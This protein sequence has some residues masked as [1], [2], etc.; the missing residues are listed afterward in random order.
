[1]FFVN[2]DG[3]GFDMRSV[4]K[5]FG[6]FKRLHHVEEFDGTGIGLA[7][8]K[9]LV[10]RHGGKVWAEGELDRSATI[11]FYASARVRRRGGGTRGNL[12]QRGGPAGGAGAG[13]RFALGAQAD[14]VSRRAGTRR[15]SNAPRAVPRLCDTRRLR[16]NQ[17]FKQWSEC[18][19]IDPSGRRKS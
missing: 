6:V 14:P 19:R 11:S 5:L 1:M 13:A 18:V 7:S 2:D 4:D 17:Q 9:R 10:E 15:R 12:E 3:V 8:V 16:K